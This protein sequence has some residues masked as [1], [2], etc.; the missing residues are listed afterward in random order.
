MSKHSVFVYGSLRKGFHNN[1]FMKDAEFVCEARSRNPEWLLN[2]FNSKSKPGAF[3]PGITEGDKYIKGE[4]Y[5]VDDE[6]LAKLDKLEENGTR[7]QRRLVN[8]EGGH[9]AWMYVHVDKNEKPAAAREQIKYD[10]A[11]TSYE[12]T[13]PREDG[14]RYIAFYGTLMMDT[15]KFKELKLEQYLEFVCEC[16]INGGL[17]DVEDDQINLNYPALIQDEPGTVRAHLFEIKDPSFLPKSDEYE[18]I[19]PDPKKSLYLREKLHLKD[20]GVDAWVYV[21]NQ[22]YS[23]FPKIPSGDWEQLV[24]EKKAKKAAAAGKPQNPKFGT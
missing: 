3:V 16:K 18:Q 11:V 6:G 4:I 23:T 10:P 5:K 22:D 12:W 9:S 24:N 13:M 20:P 8:F 17:Y 2:Q 19:D 21:Y 1:H 7:Y 15:S 14:P